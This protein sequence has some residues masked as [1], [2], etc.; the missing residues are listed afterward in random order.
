MQRYAV[1]DYITALY[2][3]IGGVDEFD[4]WVFSDTPNAARWDV[5]VFKEDRR[6][7]IGFDLRMPDRFPV[8]QY[9]PEDA[10]LIQQSSQRQVPAVLA[11]F[12]RDQIQRIML[13]IQC[14]APEMATAVGIYPKLR[15]LLDAE[16][17]VRP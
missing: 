15:E 8:G 3:I 7:H 2:R 5:M 10:R 1:S 17:D 16:S 14:F 12:S 11:K 9:A 13:L 6:A 4:V